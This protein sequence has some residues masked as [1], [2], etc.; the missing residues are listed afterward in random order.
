M[1]LVTL[2]FGTPRKHKGID[3]VAAAVAGIND[4]RA[5]LVVVGNAPDKRDINRL[6]AIAGARVKFVPNQPFS[7]IP[8]IVS[9]A[10][11]VCLAQDIHHPISSFQLPAKAI[12]AIAMGVP[13]LVTPTPPLQWL[14]EL[15]VAREI[16]E[17]SIGEIL[18]DSLLNADQ[19]TKV[20][21]RTRKIFLEHFSY[22][23]AARALRDLVSDIR[24][25]EA[26]G[27]AFA[28]DYQRFADAQKNVLALEENL[29]EPVSASGRDF[30]L[31]WKQNDTGIYGRR[32]DMFI[33]Y[34]A[35]REDVRK[36]VVFDAPI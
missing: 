21:A 18:E 34:L 7:R 20:R 3:L 15:G 2:F 14:I 30:V 13:L 29:P 9:I 17:E 25:E 10:D 23:S 11:T 5:M 28:R 24:R 36:V 1:R 22:E 26:S 19:S 6:A 31:F 33:K 27:T 32:V 4:P 8:A 12:D 35:T 16:T